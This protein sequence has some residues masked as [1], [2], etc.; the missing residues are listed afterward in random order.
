MNSVKSTRTKFIATAVLGSVLLTTLSGCSGFWWKKSTTPAA[1]TYEQ[2][3][4][5]PFITANQ[6]AARTLIRQSQERLSSDQPLIVATLVDINVLEKSS[7]LGRVAS[8]QISAAFSQAGYRMVEMK[9]RENVYI[10]RNEGELLLTREISEIAKLHKAQAVIVGSYGVG[11]N[12]VFINLKL[13]QPGTNVVLAAYDYAI[14]MD[15]NTRALL[16][17]TSRTSSPYNSA[18]Y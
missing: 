7:T 2:A 11:A 10:K 9:F 17:Y 15:S 6:T 8:E 3:A 18:N 12:A 1:Y 4:D 5:D 14:P 16:G 13:V